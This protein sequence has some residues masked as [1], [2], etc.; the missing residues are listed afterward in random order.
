MR[1]RE[2]KFWAQ[3]A[4]S[5]EELTRAAQE[6]ARVA[7]ID[8]SLWCHGWRDE[9][10][11]AVLTLH[12]PA[13]PFRSGRE[14]EPATIELRFEGRPLTTRTLELGFGPISGTATA[15][16]CDR[17]RTGTRWRTRRQWRR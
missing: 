12:P 7:G 4:L 1:R 6:A 13:S 10:V 17:T 5:W 2:R 8:P 15:K 16:G 14:V 11:E 3:A 9:A